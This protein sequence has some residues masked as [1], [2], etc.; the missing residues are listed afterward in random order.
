MIG[1]TV[2]GETQTLEESVTILSLLEAHGLRRE[3]VVVERNGEIVPRDRF[4]QV[5]VEHDDVLEIVQMMAGG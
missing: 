2:N 1:I 4:E 3:M 5:V